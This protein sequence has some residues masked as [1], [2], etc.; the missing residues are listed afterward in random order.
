M[1]LS[2]ESCYITSTQLAAAV[3]AQPLA[4]SSF[5]RPFLKGERGESESLS[6]TSYR[7]R[8]V[9]L[10]QEGVCKCPSHLKMRMIGVEE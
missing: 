5:V 9:T 3:S 1:L 2:P 4:T 6:S 7:E 8:G 10:Y